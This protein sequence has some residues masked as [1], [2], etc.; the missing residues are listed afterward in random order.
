[1]GVQGV[2][3]EPLEHPTNQDCIREQRPVYG[4]LLF[5][6]HTP[7]TLHGENSFN[8]DLYF[9]NQVSPNAYAMDALL[10]VLLNCSHR[11][12]MGSL[13]TEHKNTTR[14]CT[15]WIKGMRIANSSTLRNIHNTISKARPYHAKT[16]Y[17]VISYI[18]YDGFLWE[19]DGFKKSPLRLA[20][21]T[22]SSWFTVVSQELKCKSDILQRHHIPFTAWSVIED[23]RRTYQRHLVVHQCMKQAIEQQLDTHYSAWRVQMQ[24]SQWEEEYKHSMQHDM[25]R[26]GKSVSQELG[27]C[28]SLDD[29]PREEKTTILQELKALRHWTRYE[30]IDKWLKTQDESLQLYE[31]MGQQGQK[32]QYYKEDISRRQHPYGHFIEAYIECL[33]LH[34]YI[35]LTHKLCP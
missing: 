5:L 29:L 22:E 25:N 24:V 15:P 35:K 1:M 26:Y 2:Q 9:S 8:S 17:H 18:H 4:I 7:T 34:G 32:H 28:T 19:L 33:T 31:C 12:E 30:L 3:V 11:L 10:S 23:R 21:C 20:P 6:R 16:H 14:D 13:L 27:Y